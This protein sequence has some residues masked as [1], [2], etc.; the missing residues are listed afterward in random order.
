MER[1]EMGCQTFNKGVSWKATA[2]DKYYSRLLQKIDNSGTI[3]RK[4][5]KHNNDVIVTSRSIA[6]N[7]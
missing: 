2:E 5:D 4:S 1:E 7:K 6:V 3:E